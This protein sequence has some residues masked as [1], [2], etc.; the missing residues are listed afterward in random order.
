ME[1]RQLKWR[2]DLARTKYLPGSCAK[3]REV[4]LHLEENMSAWNIPGNPN[5]NL[6]IL[7]AFA[8]FSSLVSKLRQPDHLWW[9][10]SNLE[11]SELVWIAHCWVWVFWVTL[12][13]DKSVLEL[14]SLWVRSFVLGI[15]KD[16]CR[17]NSAHY[18][19]PLFNTLDSF[20][21]AQ[22]PINF[23][24]V[25]KSGNGNFLPREG[26]IFW[27]SI[28]TK[29]LRRSFFSTRE[30]IDDFRHSREWSILC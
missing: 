22:M 26:N 10:F 23:D 3:R 1:T 11:K 2:R 30:S 5:L 28:K 21:R 29:V 4:S 6:I 16:S 20:P 27:T 8:S 17:S 19:L 18:P 14:M 9:I 7:Y 25:F 15:A 12:E 13:V 24:K